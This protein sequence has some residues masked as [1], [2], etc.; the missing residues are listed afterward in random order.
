MTIDD[1]IKLIGS[2]STIYRDELIHMLEV[3]QKNGLREITLEEAKEYY[4]K[5]KERLFY[6]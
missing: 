6:D 3:Y 4:E 5:L 2:S 1:Y